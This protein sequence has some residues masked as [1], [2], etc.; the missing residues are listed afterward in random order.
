METRVLAYRIVFECGEP[1]YV[2]R[3]SE[4]MQSMLDEIAQMGG[5]IEPRGQVDGH[6]YFLIRWPQGG[7]TRITWRGAKKDD[8]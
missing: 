3:D 2:I 4:G 1:Q 6:P 8:G 5:L 7:P